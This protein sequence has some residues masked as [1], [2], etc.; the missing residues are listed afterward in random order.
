MEAL[1][2]PYESVMSMPVG[3]RKRFV[4]EYDHILMVRKQRAGKK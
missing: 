4:E 2:Q 3:R 1:H